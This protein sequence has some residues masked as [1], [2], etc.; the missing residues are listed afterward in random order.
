LTANLFDPVTLEQMTDAARVVQTAAE[1]IPT[2]VSARLDSTEKLN[3]GDNHIIIEIARK[4]L[5][6]FQPQPKQPE[7]KPVRALREKS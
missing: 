4:A 7:A 5:V 6:R 1:K 2:E 3:D